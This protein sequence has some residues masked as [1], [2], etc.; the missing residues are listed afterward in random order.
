MPYLPAAAAAEI[1]FPGTVQKGARGAR[2]RRVQ[3]WLCF[4][5]C[6]TAID[7]D[8]GPGTQAAVRRFQGQIGLPVTGVVDRRVWSA[9]VEPLMSALSA[10]L[11]ATLSLDEA[12]YRVATAHLRHHPIELGGDNRGPWVRTYTGGH[13]G[14]AWRWCA[15][16]VTFALGQACHATA[17]PMPIRGS[18]SCD[19]LAAQARAA[20]RF[21]SGAS[22]ESGKT[23][24]SA[25]GRCQVFL[26]RRTPTDWVHTGFSFD[27][28][29]QSFST[30]EGN[31]NDEGSANGFEVC[32][33]SRG[34][35]KK[36]FITLAGPRP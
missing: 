9:L 16:F 12:T 13:E 7:G 29:G 2:A 8:F 31:T 35:Q 1:E 33:R 30:I 25:L 17:S 5:G 3:E 34:V 15:A 4:H 10:T 26:V 20:G 14:D 32:R 21:V 6:G 19:S 22:V 11:P 24:W 27:G 23:R 36:D 28:A 18:P